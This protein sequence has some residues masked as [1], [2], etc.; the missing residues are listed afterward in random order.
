M[1]ENPFIFGKPVTREN[2]YNRREEVEAAA[3]F[4]KRL[5]SFSVVGERRI[6]K[7]SF[8]EYI[9][10]KDVLQSY[11]I[12]PETH[13]LAYLSL[14]SLYSISKESLVSAIVK[15]IME[16]TQVEADSPN[17]FDTLKTHI[18]TLTLNGRNLI[19][20]LDEFEVIAPILDSDFSHW[21]RFVFQEQN[22][23]AIT[24]SQTT[25]R[26]L[27]T[28]G[29]IASPL[30]NI[31]GNIFLRLFMRKETEDMITN[32]FHN[33]G[34]ELEKEEVTFLAD[35]SGGNP[36]FIQ[37]TGYYY[38]EKKRKNR[39]II[40][41]QFKESTA[42]HTKDQFESYWKHLTKEEKRFLF[43]IESSED[44]RVS[45][46]LERKGFLVKKGNKLEIYSLLF[47]DFIEI[48]AKTDKDLLFG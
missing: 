33:G 36:Y 42:P 2:F 16:Q 31:F 21:L 28:S 10:S 35:L 29:G 32:M 6:G 11:G 47:K 9:L 30:F 27:E 38:Y 43:Q 45:A 17:V 34:I 24:S 19:I 1:S 41:N 8:L 46:I 39:R 18:K 14:S 4:L 37:L 22:V 23:V 44:E 12:D 40:L 7:T 5:Q 25:V 15:R 48:K 26:E 20:A 13:V 3:G